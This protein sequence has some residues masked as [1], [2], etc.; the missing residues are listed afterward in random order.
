MSSTSRIRRE[1]SSER[2]LITD[3]LSYPGS[4]SGPDL[5][6]MADNEMTV[7]RAYYKRVLTYETLVSSYKTTRCHN[8]EQQSTN[9]RHNAYA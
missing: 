3:S 8:P 1:T 7:M 2:S 9:F 4:H 6:K 5:F